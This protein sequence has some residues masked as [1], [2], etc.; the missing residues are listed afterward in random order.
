MGLKL[1]FGSPMGKFHLRKKIIQYFPEHERYIEVFGGS[2]AVLLGKKPSKE[3]IYNDIDKDYCFLFRFVQNLSDDKFKRLKKYNWNIGDIS[4]NPEKFYKLKKDIEEGNFKDD[5]DRFVKLIRLIQ[6]SY[7][8]IGE[9]PN[10]KRTSRYDINKLPKLKERL[11]NVKI[12]NQDWK[13]VLKNYDTKNTLFYLDPPYTES[14][15]DKPLR[16]VK[17]NFQEFLEYLPKIKGKFIA[18]YSSDKTKD[19]Q[20]RGFKVKKILTKRTLDGKDKSQKEY[21]ILIFNFNPKLNSD[22]ILMQE[23][24]LL[25]TE[26]PEFVLIPDFISIT[27]SYI[28]GDNPKDIDLVLKIPQGLFDY[29]YQHN[30]DIFDALILKTQ[31]IFN[32]GKKINGKKIHLIPSSIGA[33]WDNLPIYDLVLRPKKQEEI[34]VIDEP[35]FKKIALNYYQELRSATPEI[36]RQAETSKEQDKIELFRFF[37]PLKTKFPAIIVKKENNELNYNDIIE[38]LNESNISIDDVIIQ[39]K[40]DGNRVIFHI[41]NKNKKYKIFSDDGREIDINKFQKTIQEFQEL[42][43]ENAI[44]DSEVEK[45]T[46]GRHWNR[47]DVAGYL[48]NSTEFDDFG[49]VANIFDVLYLNDQDLHNLPV[50]DRIAKLESLNFKQST[51]DVPDDRFHLNL[52]PSFKLNKENLIK[53]IEA[54]ASEGAMIKWDGY[55]LTGRGNM[56]KYK[57]YEELKVIILKQ[58]KTKTKGVYNY[59]IGIGFEPDDNIDP[60]EIVKLNDKSYHH[61]GRTYNT[62]LNLKPGEIISVKF[63]TMNLYTNDYNKLHIYEPI[64]SEKQPEEVDPDYFKEV[65]KQTQISGLLKIKKLSEFIEDLRNYN[66]KQVSDKVLLDDHRILMAWLAKNIDKY[67]KNLIEEKL[68]EIW[69]EIEKRGFKLNPDKWKNERAKELYKVYKSKYQEFKTDIDEFL[70]TPDENKEWSYVIQ[71]HFR[72]STVHF[73]LR[74]EREN[75]LLGWTLL[76]QIEDKIK[77]PVLNLD[78]AKEYIKQK[79]VFKLDLETG[80]PL[81]REIR[82]GVI[83]EAEIRAIKKLPEPKDWLEFEGV[84]APKQIGGTAN[85]PGVFL[86]IDKGKVEYGAKKPGFYEYF[87][88]GKILKGRYIFRALTRTENLQENI[89][90]PGEEE[91]TPREKYYYVMIKPKDETPYVIS[92]RA[93]KKNYIPEI[94]KSE[95][96]KNIREKIP[97][98]FQYW[99]EKTPDKIKELRDKLVN[100]LDKLKIFKEGELYLWRIWWKRYTKDGKPVIVIRWGPS[101]ELFLLDIEGRKF[102]CEYNPLETPTLAIERKIKTNIKRIKHKILDNKSELNPTKNTRATMELITKDSINIYELGLDFIKFGWYD[103][104]IVGQRMDNDLWQFTIQ[105]L[106]SIDTEKK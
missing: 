11:K 82:G 52:T 19:F 31:R 80:R 35:D 58:N 5:V 22:W 72:G 79:D 44:F 25:N 51:I 59:E 70:I 100:E 14:E 42:N 90:P 86:I 50:K 71:A 102:E 105:D 66:P 69:R 53:L 75:D 1:I 67:P 16:I 28:Y 68:L 21:E 89:L 18:S 84:S 62:T 96:P 17:F 60:D 8:G 32:Q 34:E 43:I 92:K 23:E 4:K 46:E 38:F 76:V 81:K 85:F 40:Y 57:I 101:T 91:E 24:D 29:I 7:G 26:F 9:T 56:L 10:L 106:P 39:K 87:F 95:L 12:L 83:R 73:D 30:R 94:N 98:D 37:Y 13:T 2:G 103:K 63:H 48:H 20:E 93:V 45:W 54:P 41:D 55:S 61:I 99:N 64:I 15:K 49:I 78:Q 65:I 88:D 6:G 36:K 3:E 74:L 104:L 97:K 47:E 77:E 27:G 33:T